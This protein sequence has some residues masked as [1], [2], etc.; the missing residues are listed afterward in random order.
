MESHHGTGTK[1]INELL[2]KE[3]ISNICIVIVRYFGGILLGAGPLSRAYLN[4]AKNAILKCE[5]KEIYE[6]KNLKLS[7]DYPKYDKINFYLKDLESKEKL[8]IK[9]VVFDNLVEISID[10]I[11]EEYENIILLIENI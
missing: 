7:I 9:K 4:S 1:A 6:Y 5:K 11:S 8:I 10:I 2:N 3:V